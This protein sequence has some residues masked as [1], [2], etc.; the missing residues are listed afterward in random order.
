MDAANERAHPASWRGTVPPRRSARGFTLIELLIVVVIIAILI[1][2][3]LPA[4]RSARASARTTQCLANQRSLSQAMVLYAGDFAE[5]IVRSWTDNRTHP[6]SWN[7]WPQTESGIYLSTAQ[8]A[9]ATHVEDHKH[10]VR[11]GAL[12]QFAPDVRAYHCPSDRRDRVRDNASSNLA[13][14]TY[15]MPNFLNGDAYWEGQI[16]GFRP[17][18]RLSQL[19]RP[20]DTFTFLEESDPRGLNMG[21]WVMQLNSPQ[22]I[23]PLTVWHDDAG[24]VGFADGHSA[25]RKWQD[26]RTRRMSRDQQF[27]GDASGN[28]DYVWLRE[29][30]QRR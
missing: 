24:V 2:L 7:D 17:V 23:D 4:I 11:A 18:K 22:W 9:A 8:L 30:W 5:T 27:Y 26:P 10:G 28:A 19:W 25:I 12:F 1:A 6:D 20:A 29:R 13:W 3:V 21:A 14:V 15:S 16:G